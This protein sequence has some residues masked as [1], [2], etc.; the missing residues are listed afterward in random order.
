MLS[1][2]WGYSQATIY[3]RPTTHSWWWTPAWCVPEILALAC[4]LGVSFARLRPFMQRR[5]GRILAVVFF[6]AFTVVPLFAATGGEMIRGAIPG[7][8][9]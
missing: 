7:I 5:W 8:G 6:S 1:I 9:W 2:A 3:N 4:L